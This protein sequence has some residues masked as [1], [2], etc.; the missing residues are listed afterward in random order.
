MG[1]DYIVYTYLEIKHNSGT[2]YIEL[3]KKEEWYCDCLEPDMDSDV[4]EE[5]YKTQCKKHIE[6]FLKPSFQPIL[7]YQNQDYLTHR[8]VEKYF[9]MIKNKVDGRDPSPYWRDV[10]SV[11]NMKEVT[12]IRKIEIREKS[13]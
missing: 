12:T 9:I 1:C 2:A 6:T 7:I 4:E 3:S 13:M 8:F 5:V 10:G 11:T